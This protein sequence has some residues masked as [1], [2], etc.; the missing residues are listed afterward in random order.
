MAKKSA[1]R[2][3]PAHH[4]VRH[5]KYFWDTEMLLLIFVVVALLVY[6]GLQ[7]GSLPRLLP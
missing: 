2:A 5:H 4:A 7:T 6:F 3:K 1:H